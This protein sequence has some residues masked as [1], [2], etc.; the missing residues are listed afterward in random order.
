MR[1][2][3]LSERAVDECAD[4]ERTVEAVPFPQI[5][6]QVLASTER[7]VTTSS[8]FDT[9]RIRRGD[10]VITLTRSDIIP[11]AASLAALDLEALS[12]V[13]V[14]RYDALTSSTTTD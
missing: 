3:Q 11:D 1:V 13:A 8:S 12:R 14:A 7:D 9:V 5:G 10:A 6:D 2:M 4:P